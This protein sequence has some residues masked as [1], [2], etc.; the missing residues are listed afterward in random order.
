MEKMARSS[1]QHYWGHVALFPTS[2]LN[3]G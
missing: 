2:E 1:P 3:K